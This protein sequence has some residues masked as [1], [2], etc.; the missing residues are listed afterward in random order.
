MKPFR[1]SLFLL[2]G[3][4]LW[5]AARPT[6]VLTDL[7]L[8]TEE[9]R[10]QVFY[11]LTTDSPT[12]ELPYKVRQIGK[13]LSAGARVSAVRAM[14]AVVRTYA[15]SAGFRNRYDHWLRDQ[16]RVSDEQTA[17]ASRAENASMNDVQAAVDQQ[18][19]CLLRCP[20]P[21]CP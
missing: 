15:Q 1:F 10:N 13:Q 7:K 20:R 19:P 11:Q 12:T 3:A 4:A 14:G 17:E 5:I 8:T 21:R 16:Y 9:V 2:T 18:T 6:N